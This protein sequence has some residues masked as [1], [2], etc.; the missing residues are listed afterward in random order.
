MFG[1]EPFGPRD[2]HVLVEQNNWIIA[3]HDGSAGYHK[4]RWGPKAMIGSGPTLKDSTHHLA[5]LPAE[6]SNVKTNT[7]QNQVVSRRLALVL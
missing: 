7:Q 6:V 3:L 2:R 1:G 4:K 5:L